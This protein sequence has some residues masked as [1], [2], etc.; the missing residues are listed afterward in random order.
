MNDF[1]A[2]R[3]RLSVRHNHDHICVI[4]FGHSTGLVIK[5]VSGDAGYT[6]T[7]FTMAMMIPAAIAVA[8]MLAIKNLYSESAEN[9]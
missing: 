3:K 2:G 1:G 5:A 6:I 9:R 7:A 8:G 4:V